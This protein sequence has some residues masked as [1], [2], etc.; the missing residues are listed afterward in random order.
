MS[1]HKPIS[2]HMSQAAN[3]ESL[4]ELANPIVSIDRNLSYLRDFVD[5]MDAFLEEGFKKTLTGNPVLLSL[6][7]DG[8]IKSSQ[9]GDDKKVMGVELDK[10]SKFIE[11]FPVPDDVNTEVGVS[12]EDG[13]V[14]ITVSNID[15]NYDEIHNTLQ[16]ISRSSTRKRM[17]YSSALMNLTNG[18]E[19]FFSELVH[20]YYADHPGAV[21]SKSAFQNRLS[22]LRHSSEHPSSSH[23]SCTSVRRS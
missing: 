7:A 10:L 20:K 18:V 11:K 8:M 23:A 16:E 3:M 17:L 1:E 2:R 12:E 6:I 19:V 15:D 4:P 5:V 13:K 9:S 14:K 21:S 22:R